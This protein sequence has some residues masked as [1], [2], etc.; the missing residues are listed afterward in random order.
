MKKIKKFL[1]DNEEEIFVV[2]A[3]ALITGF[4]LKYMYDAGQKVGRHNMQLI[5][6]DI[7]KSTDTDKRMLI[8]T[9]LDG[10]ETILQFIDKE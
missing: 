6:G 7:V 10:T 3:T 9:S 8:L 4:G 5:A 2:G 1:K